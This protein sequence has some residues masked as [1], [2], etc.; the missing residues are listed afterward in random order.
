MYRNQ[1]TIFHNL[2]NQFILTQKGSKSKTVLMKRNKHRFCAIRNFQVAWER[3]RWAKTIWCR[4]NRYRRNLTRDAR[5]QTVMHYVV[6]FHWPRATRWWQ[7]AHLLVSTT[8]FK[9]ALWSMSKAYNLKYQHWT[10]R[11]SCW[12]TELKCNK[13]NMK[14]KSKC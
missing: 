7:W 12:Q 14:I 13:V 10:K 6:Q 11:K 5:Q 4:V 1:M 9:R 3:I 2:R 8:A